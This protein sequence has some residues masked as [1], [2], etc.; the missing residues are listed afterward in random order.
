MRPSELLF[1]C[2][3]VEIALGARKVKNTGED[4][5]KSMMP[6]STTEKKSSFSFF[7]DDWLAQRETAKKIDVE[8]VATQDDELTSAQN[9]V[10]KTSS[11]AEPSIA[12]KLVSSIS[13][14][15]K[16]LSDD[17]KCRKA[18]GVRWAIS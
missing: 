4:D 18:C 8:P 11:F 14:E 3:E 16:L 2:A 7:A 10:G 5:S 9:V 15:D 1:A 17:N 13:P 12:Q 6:S